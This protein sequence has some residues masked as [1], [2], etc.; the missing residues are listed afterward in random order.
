MGVFATI[1]TKLAAQAQATG[2]VMIDTTHRTAS[3][4]AVQKEGRAQLETARPGR[5]AGPPHS[6]VPFGGPDLGL[7]RRAG[8]AVHDPSGG[9]SAGRPGLRCRLASQRTDQIGDFSVH[10]IKSQPNS[11]NATGCGTLSP[12]PQEREYLRAPKGLAQGRDA[13][14]PLPN[15]V[16]LR[17][18]PRRYRHLLVMGLDR[19]RSK[20]LHKPLKNGRRKSLQ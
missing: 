2:M 20:D 19:K 3:S 10:P 1:M 8:V 13:V 16:P 12:A 18:R 9:C 15:P 4:L 6:H 14:R 17:M 11:S 7:H 5:R